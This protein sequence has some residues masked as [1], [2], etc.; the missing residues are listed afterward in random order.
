MTI[1]CTVGQ[2]LWFESTERFAPSG[3]V[4]VKAVGRR[5]VQLAQESGHWRPL[6][7]GLGRRDVPLEGYGSMGTLWSSK[8]EAK[9]SQQLSAAWSS[10]CRSVRDARQP[11][12]LT[13]EKLQQARELLGLPETKGA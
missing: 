3:Y 11:A 5:W 7:I 1:E 6:K 13:L 4:T 2:R 8:E 10:F 12:G 9:S